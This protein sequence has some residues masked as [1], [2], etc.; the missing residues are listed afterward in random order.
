MKQ[1]K[2]LVVGASGAT[3]KLLVEQLIEKN[4]LVK[5]IVRNKSV[6]P[7]SI[8]H[9]Q[10]ISIVEASLLELKDIELQTHV[11]D[12]DSVASCL[13]HNPN[14]KGIFGQPRKLVTIATENLCKAIIANKSDIPTKY[15]LMNTV[16]NR[17][18][19]LDEPKSVGEKIVVGLLRMF[20]PPQVDNE[21]AADYLRIKIGQNNH[22]IEWVAVR[23]VALIDK[24][25]VSD[26]LVYP[27]PIGNAIFSPDKIFRINVAHFMTELITNGETWNLWKG[28]M[29]VIYNKL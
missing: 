18:R 29:P 9:H 11:K 7:D 4:H 2:T 5:I 13:G 24:N 25:E 3:G 17:N 14:L 28:Q 12:C 16:G 23:P 6:L 27:S 20:L 10:N 8:R 21:Q 22:A 26:Y 19:D 1:M 15:V